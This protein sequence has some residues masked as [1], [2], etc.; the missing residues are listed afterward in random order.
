MGKILMKMGNLDIKNEK[1][2]NGSANIA[3]TEE[4]KGDEE[5]Q[6]DKKLIQQNFL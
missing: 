5:I 1:E 6:L 4:I 3:M 2:L